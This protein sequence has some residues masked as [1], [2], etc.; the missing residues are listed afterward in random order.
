VFG[1]DPRGQSLLFLKQSG[2]AI[3]HTGDVR[4][5]GLDR[6]LSEPGRMHLDEAQRELAMPNVSIGA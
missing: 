3:N 2:G 4:A 1:Y 6:T 5:R